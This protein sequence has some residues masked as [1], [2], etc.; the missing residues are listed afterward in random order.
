M[1][2]AL[3]L[4]ITAA[5]LAVATWWA[6]TVDVSTSTAGATLMCGDAISWSDDVN[7]LLGGG[8]PSS[9]VLVSEDAHQQIEA[10][11]D[12]RTRQTVIGTVAGGA[13][14]ICAGFAVLDWRRRGRTG[15]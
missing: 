8:A 14:V 13:T 9:Q 11:R 4:G 7:R 10:C 2:V 5:V 15:S 3:W 1:R 6:L 12:A